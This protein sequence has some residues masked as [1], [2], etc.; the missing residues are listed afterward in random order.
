[1]KVT[2]IPACGV[3]ST[4]KYLWVRRVA[5]VIHKQ[6]DNCSH[7]TS[8]QRILIPIQCLHTCPNRSPSINVLWIPRVTWW[9]KLQLADYLSLAQSFHFFLCLIASKQRKLIIYFYQE[10]YFVCKS[11]SLW[12]ELGLQ[13]DWR[14]GFRWSSV[15]CWSIQGPVKALS[16]KATQLAFWLG[17]YLTREIFKWM[18]LLSVPGYIPGRK[19]ARYELCLWGSSFHRTLGHSILLAKPC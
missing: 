14:R 8:K 5:P 17:I 19:E 16:V 13:L 18:W 12:N 2:Q 1:M 3:Q 15:G 4:L 7:I 9:R 6:V 10:G 11:Q